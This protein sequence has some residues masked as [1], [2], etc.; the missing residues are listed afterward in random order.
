MPKPVTSK[1]LGREIAGPTITGVRSPYRSSQAAGITPERL[2]A[3]VRAADDGDVEAYVTLA[4]EMEERD[5]HYAS[6]IESRKLEVSGAPWDVESDDEGRAKE[7]H[8]R[9]VRDDILK[10]DG[11]E[12]LVKD[13]LDATAKGY[14]ICEIIWDTKA[15][16]WRPDEYKW[17][18][19]RW[20]MWDIETLSELRIITEKTPHGE[21]L[22][23]H[24][25]VVHTSHIRSGPSFRA[26]LGRIASIAFMAKSFTVKDWL[27]FVE[28]YGMPIRIGKYPE[29]A[30]DDDI[31]ALEKAVHDIGTD[32]GGVIPA[33]MAIEL[34]QPVTGSGNAADL[35]RN[36]ADWWDKQVSKAVLGQTMTTDEGASLSQSQTHA[37][38]LRKR[39]QADARAVARTI[40]RYVVRP[41]ID[42]NFGPQEYYPR[43]RAQIDDPEDQ[44]AK[45]RTV[46]VLVDAG[47]RIPAAWAR[48][49][50]GI[51]DPEEDEEILGG[52]PLDESTTR[53]PEEA[54]AARKAFEDRMSGKDGDEGEEDGDEDGDETDEDNGD[55]P[56]LNASRGNKS[57]IDQIVDEALADW[58]PVASDV[59]AVL[60]LAARATS[61]ESLKA[62]LRRFADGSE[63]LNESDFVRRLAVATFKSRGLGDAT[64]DP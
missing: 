32:A 37:D 60:E 6:V 61:F 35:F 55:S 2:G 7:E 28:V 19:Q 53:T 4:E 46:K 41:Y 50:F 49:E 22:L 10:G 3:I 43:L 42:L 34:L 44:E 11:F 56:D 63:D 12:G 18:T 51:P 16:R 36:K 17:R 13:L 24:K 8:V 48:N 40:N 25:Y 57:V 20:F 52:S 33:N 54:E 30:L 27:A 9:A 39:V 62:E 5:G 23:P 29:G 47:M 58:E 26:G 1:D 59:A 14:S 21:S 45:S 64:D 31:D 38:T 15:K